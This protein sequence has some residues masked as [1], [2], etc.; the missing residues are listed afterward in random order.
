MFE[1]ELNRVG[2]EVK[3]E[4]NVLFQFMIKKNRMTQRQR[5]KFDQFS[6]WKDSKYQSEFEVAEWSKLNIKHF[7]ERYK[8]QYEDFVEFIMLRFEL[9]MKRINK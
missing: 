1:W 9:F 8:P 2:Y 4:G 6:K 5:D 3:H 7:Y